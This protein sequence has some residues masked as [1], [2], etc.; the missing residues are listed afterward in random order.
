MHQLTPHLF[1]DAIARAGSIRKA[2]E[3]LAIT[4]TALNRRV[5]ALEDEL[6]V[7]IFERL[8]RG[9]RL[10]TAGELLI[11]HLRAQAADFEKLKSQI[12]DL[13][14]E[15]RGNVTIACSQAL[16]PYFLPDHIGRYRR[17][18]PGVT[19]S[20]RVRDRAAAE[21]ALVEHDADIA[22]IFEPVRMSEVQILAA[23]R[24]PIHAVMAADHPLAAQ[25]VIRLRECQQYP[26]A[27]PTVQYG[28]RH[29]IDHALLRS[30][31]RLRV[32]VDSDNFE[33]LRHYPAQEH[34]ISFQ[35]PI[36]LAATPQPE[37]I[38]SRPVDPR[39][40]PEGRLYLCQLRGRTL[41]V[42]A[43]KFAAQIER[44]LDSR[45]PE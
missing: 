28:V 42:A 32:V 18:H 6:G 29:L 40:I 4:S 20:V 16:L 9:V 5:L 10:S 30:S 36:G 8:P 27:L 19:F 41:P 17:D 14:G 22:L 43:A 24:Q 33:F 31:V 26:I 34:L 35:I 11:S 13:A 15:R 39:D 12:A 44:D 45:F 38:V 21:A 25:S 2:A 7:P 1:I 3:S 23:V 37:G